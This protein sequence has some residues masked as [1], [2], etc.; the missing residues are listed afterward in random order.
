M[1]S[2]LRVLLAG[3]VW[4]LGC[5]GTALA[6]ASC[7]PEEFGSA[8]DSAG[9][10]LRAY[11]L[12]AAPRLQARIKVLATKKGWNEQDAEDS[13]IVYLQDDR[14]TK[15]DETAN[16]LLAKIDTLG[17]L[18]PGQAIDCG[19]LDELK[20]R[21][22]EGEEHV[23]RVQNRRRSSSKAST[24]NV[25][26]SCGRTRAT[27]AAFDFASGGWTETIHHNQAG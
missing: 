23:S 7:K 16:T 15:L 14:I 22:N 12:E 13:A 18:E 6:A 10:S 3:A 21:S 20:T 1:N 19:K 5:Y 4:S 2:S 24:S 17:R 9:A 11:N 27:S 25:S 26:P 8:V